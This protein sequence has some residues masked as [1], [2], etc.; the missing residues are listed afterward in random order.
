M[1]SR[2]SERIGDGIVAAVIEKPWLLNMACGMG[3]GDFARRRR[4][5]LKAVVA[6]TAAGLLLPAVAKIGVNMAIRKAV[7]KA[8]KSAKKV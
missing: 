1:T 4:Y 2:R 5:G 6:F 8:A 3:A 7:A